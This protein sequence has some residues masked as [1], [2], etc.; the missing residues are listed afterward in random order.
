LLTVKYLLPPNKMNLKSTLQPY[1]RLL[2]DCSLWTE[3]VVTPEDT[4]LSLFCYLNI[5]NNEIDDLP[6]F[7]FKYIIH[8]D[9]RDHFSDL[10]NAFFNNQ[11]RFK[12]K[13]RLLTDSE[14]FELFECKGKVEL[15]ELSYE[16]TLQMKRTSASKTVV[17]D[18]DESDFFY[19]ETAHMTQTGGWMVDAKTLNV[20]WDEQTKKIY[21]VS[22]NYEPRFNDVINFY[23]DEHQDLLIS[24]FHKCIKEGIHYDME[25]QLQHKDGSKT[26]I[27]TKGKPVYDANHTIIKARGII[28]N[29]DRQKRKEI[30]LKESFDIILKQNDR[31]FNF[32]HIVSHN[33]RSHSGNFEL[34]LR[35]LNDPD[36]TKKDKQEYIENLQLVSSSLN[37]TIS[38]LNEVVNMRDNQ[39]DKVSIN[40][41]E[42]FSTIKNAIHQS[43]KDS[44]AKSSNDKRQWIGY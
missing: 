31:L 9:D 39:E 36:T 16:L 15:V 38:H 32:A 28:Q 1:P 17:Q 42:S 7:F 26:W 30:K 21:N 8:P 5:N 4:W 14:N 3:K 23:I 37:E 11:E 13:I 27:R 41:Q 34:I 19:K 18:P 33:L 22:P 43:I 29:I 35:L 24:A 40:V 25:L 10:L 6:S 2:R 12:Y 44:K 20:F